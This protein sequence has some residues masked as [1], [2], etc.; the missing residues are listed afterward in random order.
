MI[1]LEFKPISEPTE[2]YEYITPNDIDLIE[3][4]KS[5]A[6]RYIAPFKHSHDQQDE[7]DDWTFYKH[8]WGFSFDI[9]RKQGKS[10]VNRMYPMIN[11]K[12]NVGNVYH[13]EN[14]KLLESWDIAKGKSH[15]INTA[16]VDL[17]ETFMVVG[18]EKYWLTIHTDVTG[19]NLY[20][21]TPRKDVTL[22]QINESLRATG[23]VDNHGFR[24]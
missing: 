21:V 10:R 18:T 11:K 20:S 17:R 14:K 15:L 23:K 3:Q 16:Y 24:N 7:R 8:T 13:R 22:T 5:Y 6:H 9:A 19:Q 2:L 12:T 4:I 1:G